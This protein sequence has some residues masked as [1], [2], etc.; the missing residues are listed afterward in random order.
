MDIGS[1]LVLWRGY[2]QS[3]RPAIRRMLINVDISTAA[4]YREGPLLN[5]C[6][7]FLGMR[8]PQDLTPGQRFGERERTRL[9]RFISNVRVD[10]QPLKPAQP[11]TGRGNRRPRVVRGI[12]RGT[13]DSTSFD[14]NGQQITIRQYYQQVYNYQIKFPKIVCVEV[15]F[16]AGRALHYK[17]IVYHLGRLARRHYPARIMQRLEGTDREETA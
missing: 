7:A 9:S 2:F 3:I 15:R 11:Q 14:R 13:A 5:T 16:I 6:L 8:Q 1:G 12:T 10:V 17:L 4:M